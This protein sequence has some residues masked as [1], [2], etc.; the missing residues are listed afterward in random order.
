MK[1]SFLLCCLFL[2][3]CS[4]VVQPQPKFTKKVTGK[5]RTVKQFYFLADD[6][7]QTEV[8]YYDYVNNYD[9]KYVTGEWQ[10][11]GLHP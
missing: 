11:Y 9:E 8:S 6:M 1:T 7:T 3:G 5:Y 2:V 10:P 4:T